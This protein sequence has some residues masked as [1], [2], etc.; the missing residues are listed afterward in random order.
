MNKRISPLLFVVLVIFL[1]ALTGCGARASEEPTAVPT[2][3]PVVVRTITPLPTQ[4]EPTA[5]AAPT[6]APSPT[7]TA[8]LPKGADLSGAKL[9]SVAILPNYKCLFTLQTDH[10][11]EAEF[12]AKVDKLKDYSCQILPRF[13]NRL[14]CTGPLGAFND[15]VTFQVFARGTDAVLYEKEVYVPGF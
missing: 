7:P 15:N 12:Y 2:P 11:L 13:P 3:K 10:A 1:L 8:T 6:L 14:Y 5:T 9:I 4:P